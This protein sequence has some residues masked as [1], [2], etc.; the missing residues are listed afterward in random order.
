M[1]IFLMYLEMATGII[2]TASLAMLI[3]LLMV[4]LDLAKEDYRIYGDSG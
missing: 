2:I 4:P 3:R 1:E